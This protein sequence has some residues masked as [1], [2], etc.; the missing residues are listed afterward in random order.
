[1][2]TA[3]GLQ[4]KLDDATKKKADSDFFD[5]SVKAADSALASKDYAGAKTNYQSAKDRL[6]AEFA[7][8]KLEAKLQQ[9]TTEFNKLGAE[10]AKKAELDSLVRNAKNA[11]DGKRFDDAITTLNGVK[12]KFPADFQQQGLQARLDDAT[13]ARDKAADDRRKAENDQ[14]NAEAAAR[15]ADQNAREGLNAL[16]KEG[17]AGKAS[18]LLEQAIGASMSASAQRRATLNAYLAVAYAAQSL[19]KNDKTLETKAR[20]QFRQAQS[21]QK[22]FKLE[23]KLVSPQ[24]KK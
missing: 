23:D 10:Q 14:R 12:S 13:R 21:I 20:D 11:Y 24:V 8:R 1:E 19:Q 15:L 9:A 22:G 18:P 2:F 4:P 7:N 3:K 6:P 17:N 5:N 16:L